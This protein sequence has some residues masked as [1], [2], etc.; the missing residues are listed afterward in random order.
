MSSH[1]QAKRPAGAVV[2]A[3][4]T[5]L[6]LFASLAI[7]TLVLILRVTR[8]AKDEAPPPEIAVA[9]VAP[10]PEEAI[11]PPPAPEPEPEPAPPP[12]APE[13]E[14]AEVRPELPPL[15]PEDRVATAEDDPTAP[16]LDALRAGQARIDRA[17]D[18]L[19]VVS[20]GLDAA[21]RQLAKLGATAKALA[22]S[23]ARQRAT[24]EAGAKDA[25]QQA[26]IESETTAWERDQ[27]RR[28][29]AESRAEW[30]RSQDPNRYAV[31]PFAAS[32]GTVQVPVVVECLP[33]GVEVLPDGPF[34]AINDIDPGVYRDSPFVRELQR[35]KAKVRVEG[36]GAGSISAEDAALYIFFAVRPGGIKSYYEARAALDKLRIAFGYELVDDHWTIEAGKPTPTESDEPD[37]V[38][39]R[40]R[41]PVAW[42]PE[43]RPKGI[44]GPIPDP[45]SPLDIAGAATEFRGAGGDLPRESGGEGEGLGRGAG[46]IPGIRAEAPPAGLPRPGPVPGGGGLPGIRPGPL[47]K[48]DRT[49][50]G[51]GRGAADRPV[52]EMGRPS[53]AEPSLPGRLVQAPPMR[54]GGMPGEPGRLPESIARRGSGP[55]S[56]LGTLDLADASGGAPDAPRPRNPVLPTTDGSR[57]GTPGSDLG[58]PGQ[59]SG[60]GAPGSGGA[61]G[62]GAGDVDPRPDR[63]LEIVIA[64]GKEGLVVRPTGLRISKAMLEGPKRDW[65]EH[66]RKIA[67]LTE[68]ANPQFR[69]N[70]AL[71]FVVEPGGQSSYWQAVGQ[72]RGAG[73]DWPSRLESVELDRIR[74]FERESR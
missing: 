63:T 72:V 9:A 4:I 23:A 10:E 20:S 29:L 46:D 16:V 19:Q 1:P 62:F 21:S 39:R 68:V 70:P 48:A 42:E 35:L 13:P 30:E 58:N 73:I 25:I 40:E 43:R 45:P 52:T 67:R 26:R 24:K 55:P 36:A 47:M 3:E 11:P 28:K 12:P 74:V 37:V 44:D 14:P 56:G 61:R 7:G 15:P 17:G 31:L 53:G 60:P 34:F 59:P 38:P 57:G 54:P 8:P 71:K 2:L 22:A 41:A 6:A 64:C 33:G 49:E 18:R 66:L 50:M 32:D 65:I 5:V 69:V 51:R 27:L